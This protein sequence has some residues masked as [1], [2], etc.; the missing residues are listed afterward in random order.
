[1]TVSQFGSRNR[2]WAVSIVSHPSGP[3]SSRVAKG[4]DTSKWDSTPRKIADTTRRQTRDLASTR[5]K[6]ALVSPIAAEAPRKAPRGAT[7]EESKVWEPVVDRLDM[8]QMRQTR[9]FGW[10]PE[11]AAVHAHSHPVSH[12]HPPP[13]PKKTTREE[14][15]KWSERL[16]VSTVSPAQK[17]FDFCLGETKV[18]EALVQGLEESKAPARARKLTTKQEAEKFARRV[19]PIRDSKAARQ[20]FCFTS[21]AVTDVMMGSALDEMYVQECASI[22]DENPRYAPVSSERVYVCG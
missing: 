3:M 15:K 18:A 1:M 22:P 5:V 10:S 9:D 6:D 11:H 2:Q 13:L 8:N 21:A 20:G 14:A 12:A 16:P 17:R 19:Q 7:K 4:R